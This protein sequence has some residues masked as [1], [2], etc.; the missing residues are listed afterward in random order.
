MGKV[1]IAIKSCLILT[2]I[3]IIDLDS[4][5]SKFL[6]INDGITY[7][8]RKMVSVNK[9]LWDKISESET[10]LKKSTRLTENGLGYVKK[11]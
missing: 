7:Q 5:S 8:G 1:Y 2:Q 9:G 10:R 3:N 4:I 11:Y 6:E